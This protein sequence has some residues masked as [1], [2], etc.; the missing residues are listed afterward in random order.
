MLKGSNT[1]RQFFYNL[2][3]VVN[4]IDMDHMA[5]NFYDE[6]VYLDSD[7]DFA[8]P[9]KAELYMFADLVNQQDVFS[10]NVT[11]D[12]HE[13]LFSTDS[14]NQLPGIY[15]LQ[16]IYS[17]EANY[18]YILSKLKHKEF[19]EY[20]VY[21]KI[22]IN[23]L[24]QAYEYTQKIIETDK[25]RIE[26]TKLQKSNS[27]LSKESKTD[28][29]TG[30]LNRRGFY[31]IGQ[32]TLDVMQEMN[33]AGIVFFFDMDGLKNINDTFGHSMGDKAIKVEAMAI[34]SVFR[35]S[36][37]IG[38]LSGDEFGVVALGMTEE[39]VPQVFKKIEK[40]N[41]EFS[42]KYN[43]PFL[44]SISFGYADLAT[45]S[46]LKKLLTEAD[47]ELYKVKRIKHGQQ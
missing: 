17:G 40:A 33:S 10:P 15:I 16:P 12:P 21:L 45:S 41:K 11:F 9:K 42:K 14:F 26:N 5:I 46:V 30:I 1:L 35:S 34:K 8:L 6:P 20:N 24:S 18:G 2:K 3:Y 37:V 27:S 31:R 13:Q 25:L 29:L 44:L 19:A 43:L 36:D 7:E 22:L 28:D 32:Q 38:R 39:M 47:K 23:S 4:Q